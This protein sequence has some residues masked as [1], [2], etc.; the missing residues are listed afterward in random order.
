MNADEIETVVN[1]LVSVLK[2]NS[3]AEI[4][5]MPEFDQFK[6]KN[7]LFYDTIVSG[8]YDPDIFKKMMSMKRKL[9]SGCTQYEVDVKFGKFMA[10]K[11]IDPVIKK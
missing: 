7:K 6:N 11:Y 4:E 5:Q 3:L 2:T 9:E 1:K 8:G 10:E